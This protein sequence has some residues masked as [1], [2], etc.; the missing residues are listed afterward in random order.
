MRGARASARSSFQKALI[1]AVLALS[2]CLAPAC[3]E[4]EKTPDQERTVYGVVKDAVN[5]K[6]LKGVSI[7]FQSDT[8]DEATTKTDGD[9]EY[10]VPVKTDSLKGRIEAKKSGYQ[11]RVSSVYFDDDDVQ[12][13]IEL[14]RN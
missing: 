1:G 12:I 5:G 11:T 8:L 3:G 10:T 2:A 4:T 9:G 7:R 6:R 13:D 14:N